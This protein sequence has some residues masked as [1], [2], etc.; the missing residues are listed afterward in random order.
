M[1]LF[2]KDPY[3]LLNQYKETVSFNS[4][5]WCGAPTKDYYTTYTRTAFGKWV[6]NLPGIFAVMFLFVYYSIGWP[7]YFVGFLIE[8]WI[9]FIVELFTKKWKDI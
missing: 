7:M 3:E 8:S 2:A 5:T 9:Y 1:K 6:D 4:T